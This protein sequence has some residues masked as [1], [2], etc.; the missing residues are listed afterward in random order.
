MPT[1]ERI[2]RDTR[3]LLGQ[4][5]AENSRWSD[6]ELISYGNDIVQQIFAETDKY[7]EGQFDKTSFIDCAANV[8]TIP[9]P[10]DCYKLRGVWYNSG[11][12]WRRL[13]YR[14]NIMA[15][16]STTDTTASG[17]N[18]EPYYYFQRNNVVL[19]PM[20]GFTS[21]NQPFRFD[22]TAYPQILVYGTDTM[23]TGISTIFK[24]MVVMY[25]VYKAK[26]K[27]DLTS[28]SDTSG[29]AG[30]LFSSLFKQFKQ[31]VSERSKAPQYV[32]VYEPV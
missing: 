29:K 32:S 27:D 14:Q 30:D 7:S 31:Q 5:K 20:P 22:Y 8:E 19:R 17:A 4:P 12:I 16:F 21:T 10:I 18:Y 13:E 11:T 3:V 25:M 26:L 15:D 2:L 6:E 1:L 23:D 24:E 28:G 9:L